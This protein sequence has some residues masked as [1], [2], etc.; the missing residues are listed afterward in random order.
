MG[1]GGG[2]AFG[3]VEDNAKVAVAGGDGDGGVAKGPG[4]G[5]R[6]AGWVEDDDLGLGKVDVELGRG[7]EGVEG[8]Q[9]SLEAGCC[10]AEQSEVVG[11]EQR[12]HG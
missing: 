3:G 6:G 1:G 11:V 12:G 5:G 10:G 7:A 4:V 2:D 8:V 9:L